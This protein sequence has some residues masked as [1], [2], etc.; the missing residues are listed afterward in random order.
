MRAVYERTWQRSATQEELK[1]LIDSYVR[2][3][4]LYREGLAMGL[5]RDDPVIRRRVGQKVHLLSEE[6]LTI[7]PTERELQAYLDANP[8]KF[9]TEP[10]YTFRHVFIDPARQGRNLDRAVRGCRS[11]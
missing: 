1:G 11:S 8:G 7:E 10:L 5:E 4:V 3:E 9:A 2:E 6:A